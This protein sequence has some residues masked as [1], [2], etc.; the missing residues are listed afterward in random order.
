LAFLLLSPPPPAAARRSFRARRP[1]S[2]R[3][4]KAACLVCREPTRERRSP[5]QTRRSRS[6]KATGPSPGCDGLRPLTPARSSSKAAEG[7]A[8][9]PRRSGPFLLVR[10]SVMKKMGELLLAL[11]IPPRERRETAGEPRS[12]RIGSL[13]FLRRRSRGLGGL[14]RLLREEIRFRDRPRREE[15]LGSRLDLREERGR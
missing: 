11:R 4:R 8:P 5:P 15:R 6:P 7:S 9:P 1:A 3:P 10:G 12:L 14:A 2:R 13:A